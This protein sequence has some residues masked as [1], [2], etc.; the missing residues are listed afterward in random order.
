MVVEAGLSG[1]GM[2]RRLGIVITLS[3]LLGL[4]VVEWVGGNPPDL[5]QAPDPMAWGSTEGASG[6]I[7][8]FAPGAE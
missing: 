1:A 2:T 3:C 7:C 4:I 5:F 8:T 6:A